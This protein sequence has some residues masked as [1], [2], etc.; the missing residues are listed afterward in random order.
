MTPDEMR[1]GSSEMQRYG[2]PDQHR[3]SHVPDSSDGVREDVTY[4][5]NILRRYW[6][7]VLGTAVLSVGVAWW[8]QR[9][10]VPVYTAEALL[11]HRPENPVTS[12]VGSRLGFGRS[13]MEFGTQ[14]EILRTGAVLAP[15]VDSLG[16]QVRLRDRPGDFTSL[17]ESLNVARSARGG[18]YLLSAQDETVYLRALPEDTVVDQGTVREP[19][20]GPDF[21]LQLASSDDL[22]ERPV[23]FGVVNREIA[24]RSLEG[25]LEIEEGKGPDL[26]WI[27]YTSPDPELAA[28]VVN[29]VAGTYQRHRTRTAVEQVRRRRNVIAEQLVE[30]ADSLNEEQQKM[31]AYQR[32]QEVLDPQ[33]QSNALLQQRLQTENELRQLRY[34]RGLLESVV[35]G[36]ESGGG[37]TENFQR[38]M[39]MGSDLIPGLTQMQRRLQELQG[40][41]TRLTAS[42]FGRTEQAPE[43]QEVD[44][45]IANQRNEIR[46]AAEE[47]LNRVESRIQEAQSRLSQIRGEVG[48][49]PEQTTEYSQLQQ[50]VSAV[51]EVF[52]KLVERYYEAQIAEGVEAGD[53]EVVD[54]AVE[55]LGPDPS[56]RRFHML[57]ALA[58]GLMIGGVGALTADYFDSSVRTPHDAESLTRLQVL[59]TVPR[60]PSS[61]G[62]ESVLLGKEAFRGIR[63]NLRFALSEPP[64]TISIT[65]S[66]PGEGKSTVAANLAVTMAEQGMMV[67]LVDADLRRPQVHRI[68]GVERS[69]GLSELLRDGLPVSDTIQ[70]SGVSNLYVI[71]GGAMVSSPADLLDGTEF[72]ALLEKLQ[73]SL[74]VIIVDTPPLRAVTDAGVVGARTEATVLVVEA[75]ETSSEELSSATEQLRRVGARLAGIIMNSVPERD[76][77]GRYGYSYYEDY[78]TGAT[79]KSDGKGKFL[80]RPSDEPADRS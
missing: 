35:A 59:G 80:L 56:R 13:G 73:S 33:G 2:G 20:R 5:L 53:I 51:Q 52:D 14:A 58:A 67:G 54:P 9:D 28:S 1:A 26:L 71:S 42:R 10:E 19:L 24:V 41:R 57:L 70:P 7:M 4:Y 43:V 37:N 45:L 27:R 46:I 6:W 62:A 31:L 40:E 69:P 21:E 77:D 55:P 61:A 36:L 72:G 18:Q 79:A 8:L 3:A 17:F 48:S 76:V 50:R 39:A 38:L 74:D 75:N 66:N 30:L 22:Q 16:L 15:V 78:Y 23:R 49:L 44:S 65:S 11:Q 29:A 47:A 32:Q 64:R 60:I 68:F 12:D 34:Q 25:S 63:T